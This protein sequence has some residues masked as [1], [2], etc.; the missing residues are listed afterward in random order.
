M[1]EHLDVVWST[2]DR[3]GVT[4]KVCR[5]PR[6]IDGEYVHER[7][8]I[9]LKRGMASRLYRTTLAHECG[10][11]VY[12]DLPTRFGPVHWKQE[13]RA[14]TWAALALIDL[15]GYRDAERRHDGNVE[16]MAVTLDVTTDLVEAY[17][18]MLL[19][20]DA[21]IYLAPRMGRGQWLAK[22]ENLI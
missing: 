10:H 22:S 1:D 12:G 20:T 2:L 6:A 9:R 8:L 7:R 21:A 15:D 16:A 4:V 3:L 19:R 11:A 18:R 5:L 13:R 17:R 14:E